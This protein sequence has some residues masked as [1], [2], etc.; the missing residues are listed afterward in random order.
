MRHRF[1]ADRMLGKL[2][3]KL[4]LLG[5]DTRY[6]RYCLPA[7]VLEI[8]EMESLAL[9]TRH[10]ELHAK[11]LRRGVESFLLKSNDWRGQLKAVVMRFDIRS[12]DIKPFTRCADC[13]ALLTRRSPDEVILLVPQYV[14][15]TH[16]HFLQC[17]ACGKVYWKGTH[18]DRIL[19][20]FSGIIP[21]NGD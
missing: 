1:L 19:Q 2:S 12:T 13:N 14:Q 3:R 17:P 7:E 6:E 21:L 16:N 5:I 20:T 4:R 15:F 10:R 8:A 18:P 9:L 11:A